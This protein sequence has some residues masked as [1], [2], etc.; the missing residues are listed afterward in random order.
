M[1]HVQSQKILTPAVEH[2]A[3]PGILHASTSLMPKNPDKV[4]LGKIVKQK[5]SFK[6]FAAKLRVLKNKEHLCDELA[7]NFSVFLF[8]KGENDLKA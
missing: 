3:L 1:K 8:E 7:K 6:V 4:K 5:I 2:L